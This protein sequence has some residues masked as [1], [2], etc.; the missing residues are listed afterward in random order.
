MLRPKTILVPVLAAFAVASAGC[1]SLEQLKSVQKELELQKERHVALKAEVAKIGELPQELEIKVE[2]CLAF[3][4]KVRK[5]LMENRTELSKKIDRQNQA[6]DSL[7]KA[8]RSVLED[9]AQRLTAVSNAVDNALK[10]MRMAV[11][12]SIEGI[13]AVPD[14]S[15]PEVPQLPEGAGKVG[16]PAPPASSKE[17]L[18]PLKFR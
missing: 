5:L 4:E 10:Q 17:G 3:V 8:Y 9:E 15:L 2:S 1:A 16:T 6:V 18:P 13:K 12:K 14:A 7:K 11:E